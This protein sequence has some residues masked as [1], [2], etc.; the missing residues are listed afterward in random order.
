MTFRIVSRE[1]H[2]RHEIQELIEEKKRTLGKCC[3]G[4]W[5]RKLEKKRTEY[6]L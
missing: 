1:V 4:M 5:L 6:K 3:T 2:G